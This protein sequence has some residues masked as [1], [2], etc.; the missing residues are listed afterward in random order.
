MGVGVGVI[1]LSSVESL[2]HPTRSNNTHHVAM[3]LNVVRSGVRTRAC[4][5][6]EAIKCQ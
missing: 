3:N 6:S 2:N 5:I 4:E 1:V